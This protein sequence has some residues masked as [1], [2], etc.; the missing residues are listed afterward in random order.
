VTDAVKLD[1]CPFCGST[2]VELDENPTTTCGDADVYVLCQE[3]QAQGP[4]CRVGCRDEEED[5]PIDL[6]AEAAEFWNRR[7]SARPGGT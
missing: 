7:G 1:P 5:G 2:D 6:E 3:C 4:P